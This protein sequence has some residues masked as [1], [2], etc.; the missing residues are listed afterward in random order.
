MDVRD[1]STQ[2]TRDVHPPRAKASLTRSA[3]SW[4]AQTRLRPNERRTAGRARDLL[5]GAA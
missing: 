4:G 3:A 1:R 2:S 5:L